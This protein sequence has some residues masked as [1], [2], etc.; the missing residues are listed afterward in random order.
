[1]AYRRC[2]GVHEKTVGDVF[3][4]FKPGL[5]GYYGF[6][7]IGRE[8][9]AAI[10]AG[11]PVEQIVD[12]IVSTYAVDADKARLDTDE[13]VRDLVGQGLIEEIS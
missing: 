7:G 6:S 11:E 9:W 5:N 10:I 3:F 1:M 4:L 12:R 8:L 13:F 2:D